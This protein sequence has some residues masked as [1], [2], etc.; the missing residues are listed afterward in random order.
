MLISRCF[1]IVVG[2]FWVQTA[3]AENW[4]QF[5]GPAG[6]GVVVGQ[7]VPHEF[8]ED[9]NVTWKTPVPGRGWSSPVIVDGL[10]WLTTAVE[11]MPT[12]DEK[13]K[14]DETEQNRGVD[15]EDQDQ[16]SVAKSV[17]LKLI[18]I[19]LVS[20]EIAK[21]IELAS[22]ERDD[23]IHAMNTYASPTPVAANGKM[24]CHFGSNGTFCVDRLS[25]EVD[26]KRQL[27]VDHGVG[28]GSSP[29]VDGD[30]LIVIQDG[31]DRQ[32]VAT[33]DVKTGETIWEK[34]RPPMS[35]TNGDHLKACS[36]PVV[37]TDR[38]GRL[39]YICL[40]AQ[41]IVSYEPETGDEI[42]RVRHGEG[43]SVV[44]RPIIDRDHVYLCS[45]YP[46]PN[47]LAIRLDGSGDVTDSH[48]SWRAKSGISSK[49]SP[50]LKNGL[51]Y[52]VADNGVAQ[53]IRATDGSTVWKSRIGGDYSA[54]PILV[55]D[56]LYF[57]SHDGKVTVMKGGEE[58]E[59]IAVNHLDGRVLASP[60]VVDG[61]LILRTEQALYRIENEVE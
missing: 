7:S 29:V 37:A 20:G 42:W 2:C 38:S 47:L 30:H 43:F 26:W 35:T 46:K 54:S 19:D 13:G 56:D 52:L 61:A 21:T 31:V 44:P 24:F 15:D 1:L 45:G 53:C 11:Q 40:G 51:I 39:Q 50:I 3:G 58:A 8:G 34:D 60:A 41:W 55:N 18:A 59:E 10:V 48:V 22:I 17:S 36:T 28:S 16:E 25:G 9:L 6:D 57:L 12:S 27:P 32:Y 14:Q 33:L 5:R 4:S 23:S 49:P